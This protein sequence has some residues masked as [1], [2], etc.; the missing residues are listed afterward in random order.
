MQDW[1]LVVVH[2]DWVSE[3][4]ECCYRMTHVAGAAAVVAGLLAC[5]LVGLTVVRYGDAA[6]AGAVEEKVCEHEGL[7]LDNE[8]IAPEEGLKGII[9]EAIVVYG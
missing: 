4:K 6:A 2:C 1:V 9:F 7:R 3:V 8:R 5:S